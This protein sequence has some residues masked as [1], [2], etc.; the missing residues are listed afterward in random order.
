[1]VIMKF[2][3]QINEFI[4]EMKKLNQRYIDKKQAEL[5]YIAQVEDVQFDNTLNLNFIKATKLHNGESVENIKMSG[6]GLGNY[7]GLIKLPKLNDFGIVIEVAGEPFWVVNIL[8]VY[9]ENPDRQPNLKESMIIQ[10]KE[11]GSFVLFSKDDN[12]T[13]TT[14]DGG[15]IIFKKGKGF[16]LIDKIGHGLSSDGEGNIT[17]S[18]KNI[19]F[20]QTPIN[21]D[22]E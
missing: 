18:G 4:R 11:A 9:T 17:I 14:Q 19:N 7:S 1:M 16:T 13:I 10:N 5:I 20:T 6:I 22:I 12:I 2:K 8:D 3:D 21:F 15:K